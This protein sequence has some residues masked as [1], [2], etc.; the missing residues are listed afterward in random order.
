MVWTRYIFIPKVMVP[1][2]QL[3]N[4]LRSPA[5]KHAA[6]SKTGGNNMCGMQFMEE[7]FLLKIDRGWITDWA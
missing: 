7:H 5:R 1:M 6:T 2:V 3:L 4:V